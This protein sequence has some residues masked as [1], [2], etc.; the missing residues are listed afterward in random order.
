[1]PNIIYSPTAQLTQ[2]DDF[3]EDC[4][5]TVKGALYVRPGQSAIISDGEA[6]HLKARGISFS[7]APSRQRPAPPAAPATPAKQGQPLAS[8]PGIPSAPQKAPQGEQK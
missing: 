8:L 2:I 6:A 3:P 5:R 1:M 4:E 7:V